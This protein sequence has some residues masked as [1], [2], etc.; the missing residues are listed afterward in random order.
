MI[1]Q[2]VKEAETKMQK[3][4]DALAKEIMTIRTGR[5]S[6]SLVDR[7]AVEYYGNPTP[8]NQLATISVPEA[9]MIIIQPWDRS[10]ISAVEKALQKSELGLNPANDGQIIR[11]PIPPLNEERRREY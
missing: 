7:I 4:L 3:S 10:V 1:E 9:R 5:A 6:P 2:N 11:V 8:L